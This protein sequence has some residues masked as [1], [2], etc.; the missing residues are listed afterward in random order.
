MFGF[1]KVFGGMLTNKR[2]FLYTVFT[3][4]NGLLMFIYPREQEGFL[5]SHT[6]L[7]GF[8]CRRGNEEDLCVAVSESVATAI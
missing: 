6:W 4:E 3:V 2:S 5:C 7:L 1:V 8:A